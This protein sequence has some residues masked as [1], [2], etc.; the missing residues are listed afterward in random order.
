MRFS[1]IDRARSPRTV[2]GAAWAGLVAPIMVAHHL[3]C[4][5]R[6]LDHRQQDGATGDVGD[7]AVIERF[8]EVLPIVGGGGLLVHLAQLGSDQA[9]APALQSPDD[10]A[11][12]SPFDGV[13]LAYDQGPLRAGG[14][15]P[16]LAVLVAL[17]LSHNRGRIAGP[18]AQRPFP[19]VTA[20]RRVR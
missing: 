11:H 9:Q 17:Y 8:A 1:V 19:P 3:P 20:L 14:S 4:P 15:P 16:A 7:E 10:L 18:V 13:R 6:A 12:Q 2:P 5:F